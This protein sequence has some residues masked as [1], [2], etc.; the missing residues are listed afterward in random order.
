MENR[1]LTRKELA[2]YLKVSIRTIDKWVAEGGVPFAK[3]HRVVRFD[4]LRIQEWISDH[5]GAINVVEFA[6]YN[7]VPETRVEDL[8]NRLVRQGYL[9]QVQ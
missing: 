6:K 4:I 5:Q 8:L 2:K 1:Y 3:I 9:E 7:R